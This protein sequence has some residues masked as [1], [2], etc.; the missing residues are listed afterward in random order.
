MTTDLDL[1][2]F[3]CYPSGFNGKENDNEIKGVGNSLDF[4]ARFYDSRI[5]YSSQADPS[6]GILTPQ[7]LNRGF[8]IPGY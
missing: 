5:V 3:Y 6:T 1:I 7:Y 2:C 8:L 4:G